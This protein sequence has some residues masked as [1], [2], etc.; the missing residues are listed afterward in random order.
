MQ[1]QSAVHQSAP[2]SSE[3]PQAHVARDRAV[4]KHLGLVKTIAAEFESRA[5]AHVD[6]D[7]LIQEGLLGVVRAVDGGTSVPT[8]I[9][10]AIQKA[11][12]ISDSAHQGRRPT[13]SLVSDPPDPERDPQPDADRVRLLDAAGLTEDERTHMDA[14][15]DDPTAKRG[16]LEWATGFGQR[17]QHRIEASVASK[18]A[19]VR[20]A[21]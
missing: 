9:R 14:R 20:S 2:Q 16:G 4:R 1:N 7:D 3:S 8:G 6:L 10:N 12:G 21:S 13:L 15:L 19:A 18:I 11:C 17:R 5:P